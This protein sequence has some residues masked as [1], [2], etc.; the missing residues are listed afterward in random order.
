M[1]TTGRDRLIVEHVGEERWVLPSDELTFGRSADLVVDANPYLHRILGRFRHDGRHWWMDNVGRSVALTVLASEELSSATVGPGSSAPLLA[2][3][4]AYELE[5]TLE[6]AERR[7]DLGAVRGDSGPLV[8][9][10]WG[11]VE[12]NPDQIDLL[13][14][15]CETRLARPSDQWAPIPSNRTCA[16]RLGWTLAKFNR[17][18]D[19]LCERLQRA[20]VRG[21]HGDLGLSAVD[22][23]R[24]L[25]DHVVRTGL[26]DE[27]TSRS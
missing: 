20:G 10:E 11:R 2:G 7:A 5:V 18:L 9:L 17:K 6:D 24:V 26:L 22:R 4:V 23:R 27:V 25:V 19:H 21:V 1:R 12:L 8:T 15:L 3:P 16:A 13:S 14:V